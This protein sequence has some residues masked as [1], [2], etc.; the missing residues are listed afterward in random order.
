MEVDQVERTYWLKQIRSKPGRP[1]EIEVKLK[2][3]PLVM[4]LNHRGKSITGIRVDI[5]N[6]TA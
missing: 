3:K 1:L 4:E 2:G 5:P 6:D